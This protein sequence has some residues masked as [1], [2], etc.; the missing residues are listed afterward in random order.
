MKF[1]Q[2]NPTTS[3]FSRPR[4]SR[5]GGAPE[6][7]F[8][9]TEAKVGSARGPGSIANVAEGGSCNYC[10]VDIGGD[11]VELLLYWV[12]LGRVESLRIGIVTLHRKVR[13]RQ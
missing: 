11:G 2:A 9:L 3:V 10:R 6:D 12:A 5:G 8:Q 1:A 7:Q 4:G 13:L